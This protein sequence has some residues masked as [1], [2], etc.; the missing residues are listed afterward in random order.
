MA[1]EMVAFG[2]ILIARKTIT[3][4]PYIVRTELQQLIYGDNTNRNF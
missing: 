4:A 1:L 3:R 2:K